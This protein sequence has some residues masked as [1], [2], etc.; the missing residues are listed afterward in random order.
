[1]TEQSPDINTPQTF[2]DFSLSFYARPTVQHACLELQNAY[3]AD[4]NLLLFLVFQANRGQRLSA[5]EISSINDE[6]RVWREHVIQP[7]RQLRRQL[8]VPLLAINN[9]AQERLRKEVKRLE[10]D[11][12]KLQQEFLE[13][14]HFSAAPL[15]FSDQPGNRLSI[16]GDNLKHYAENLDIPFNE[17]SLNTLLEA[18]AKLS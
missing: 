8:K 17:P 7:L 18:F 13:T 14:L 5:L 6:V 10:L 15:A 9:E 4:V 16:A 3:K 2:W 1:M 12:E 11:S